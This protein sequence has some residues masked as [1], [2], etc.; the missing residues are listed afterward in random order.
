MSEEAFWRE[1]G[2]EKLL[3][4]EVQTAERQEESGSPDGPGLFRH[5]T[6]VMGNLC[7]AAVLP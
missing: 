7:G 2:L 3:T 6:E 1:V 5:L 4:G